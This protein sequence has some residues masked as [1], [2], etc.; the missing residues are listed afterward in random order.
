VGSLVVAVAG[1]PSA[2]PGAVVVTGPDGYSQAITTTTTLKVPPGTYS[3]AVS[4]A[5]GTESI[6][7]QAFDGS[8]TPTSVAVVANDTATTTVSYALR[9]GSGKLWIPQFAS[10]YEAAGLTRGQLLTSG[11]P[12]P[13]VV[14]QGTT[15][16]GE[17]IAFDGEG[18][19]W[20]S[21]FSGHLYRYDATSLV[22]SGTP[23]PAVAIDAT[24]YGK[25]V[26]LAFDASGN[27]WIADFVGHRLLGYSPAQ[28]TAGGAPTPAVIITANGTSLVSPT[29][30]AFD[31]HGNL[32][33]AN[34]AGTT[35][36]RFS[37]TQLAATGSPIP[38]VT[39]S[40]SGGSLDNPYALA[41]DAGGNLWVS[42]LGA[43]VVRFDAAQLA[44]SGSPTPAATI[45]N[46][47]LSNNPVG[48]AFDANGALWVGDNEGGLV[49]STLRRFTNPGALTGS[50][51][52]T[53]SVVI[54]GLGGVDGLLMAFSPP[55][56]NLPINTP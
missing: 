13:D 20:M 18:N 52:P 31:G 23:T 56:A 30:I 7:P 36:V 41:F 10:S 9:P 15:N 8:A 6:A 39:L 32:W 25:P 19:M 1:L 24:A 21:D 12:T 27:L 37:P 28:L 44:S 38:T 11:S 51:A 55:P 5:R 16:T 40:S 3:I 33:V 34:T 35:V 43:T 48:L 22:G 14:L 49:S 54:T 45:A 17:G 42:N 4:E 50:V 47:S 53:A 46:S 29:G 26:G 2:T